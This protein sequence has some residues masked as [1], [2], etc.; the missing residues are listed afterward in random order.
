MRMHQRLWP[1]PP[2]ALCHLPWQGARRG[3]PA[4]G[5]PTPF[6]GAPTLM[7][8]CL[9]L[10]LQPLS[11]LSRS[12]SSASGRAC[13]RRPRLH[14]RNWLSLEGNF[15]SNQETKCLRSMPCK[16]SHLRPACTCAATAVAASQHLI[17]HVTKRPVR[18]RGRPSPLS[19]ARSRARA[20]LILA[21]QALHG[22]G[23]REA[24][25]GQL[26][27]RLLHLRRPVPASVKRFTGRSTGE[28]GARR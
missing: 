3:L 28:R 23:R 26:R 18:A 2:L 13:A 12:L 7:P 22:A 5:P 15:H 20:H 21:Q 10:R 4:S 11:A 17:M 27:R 14:H 19:A 16:A 25:A 1:E 24:R 8:R 9:R 6:S